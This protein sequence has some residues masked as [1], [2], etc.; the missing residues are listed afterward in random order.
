MRTRCAVVALFG[1]LSAQVGRAQQ[2]PAAPEPQAQSVSGTVTSS[3]TGLPLPSVSVRI[4][5]TSQRTTS[6]AAGRYTVQVP[7][8]SDTL[9][10]SLI[11][12][13]PQD[14]PI[15]GRSEVDVQLAAL[16]A[17]LEAQVV[18][19]YRVQDRGTVTGAVSSVAGADVINVPVDNLSNALQGRLSGVTVTQNAGT[20]GRESN[21]RVR[22]VGT[23]N[24]A[25]PLYVIDGVVSDKFAF[26]GLNPEDMENLS[27]LK[28]GATAALY[29]S[30]AANGVILVT[31]RRGAVKP[32]EFAYNVTVGGQNA[33]RIPPTL[34]AYQ[35]ART[36]ND[37]LSYNRFPTSDVRY[38]TDD[39]LQYFQTHSWDWIAAL[40]RQPLDVQHSLNISGGSDGVRYFLGGSF[41]DETGSFDNLSFRRTTARGNLDVDLTSHLKASVDFNGARQNRHGPSWTIGAWKQEDLY[42]A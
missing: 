25:D 19:A 2:P 18:T 40:W 41:L 38:Y 12:Y 29:G 15:A 14:V 39:E 34:D 5:G 13:H 16:P 26:D 20:P 36:I 17:Q 1:L 7:S 27:V 35:H 37:F 11:G 30:R 6:N 4:K 21:I 33:P 23:F 8:L 24:N 31:T 10:F 3:V 22:A 9:H 28:D 42:K 32:T